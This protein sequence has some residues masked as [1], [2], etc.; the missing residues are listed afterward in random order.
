M[1][2]GALVAGSCGVA[3]PLVA[4][5]VQAVSV[6]HRHRAR[7]WRSLGMSVSLLHPGV[8]QG[9]GAVEHRRGGDM[10]AAVGD[11]VAG[12]LELEPRLRRDV[13]RRGLHVT[14]HYPS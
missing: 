12:T 14:L 6:A 11:K 4:G 2:G 5:A 9:H 10:V 3:P 8:A 13:G 1:D 7:A